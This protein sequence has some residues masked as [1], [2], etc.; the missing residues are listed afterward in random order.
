MTEHQSPSPVYGWKHQREGQVWK[1][2]KHNS[3]ACLRLQHCERAQIKNELPPS[4][5]LITAN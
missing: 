4:K 1:G 2:A 5:N 3:D